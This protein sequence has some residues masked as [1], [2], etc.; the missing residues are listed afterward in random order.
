MQ[1]HKLMIRT[2]V[3]VMLVAYALLAFSSCAPASS[4]ASENRQEGQADKISIVCTIFPQYDWTRQIIGESNMDRFELTLLIDGRVD[5]H[6]YNPSVHDMATIRNSD[7]LI[8]VGGDSDG[9]LNNVLRDANSDMVTINLL[10]ILGDNVIRD[11]HDHDDDH[12]DHNDDDHDDQGDDHDD[13]DDHEDDDDHD[14][15]HDHEEAYTDEHVW[16]SLRNARLIC[17][18]IAAILSE[19][20]PG[21]AQAYMDNL[22]DFDKKL[23]N[24]DAKY[25]AAADA[26]DVSTLVFA[27]RFPFR[28]LLDDYNLHHYAAFRGCSAETEASFVTI[29]SLADRLNQ[30]DL[31]VV[32]VTECADQSIA[33]TVIDSSANKNQ[34]ILVLDSMQSVTSS[35]IANGA[36]YLSIMESNLTVLKDALS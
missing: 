8:Y 2:V 12:D 33:R 16:L 18:A 5:L 6:S 1:K 28:Y 10:E 11:E 17:D 22:R 20:D 14:D 7:V 36:T 27:A 35:D 31:G 29:I 24:L 26:S 13:D 32:M 4:S 23:S 3:C 15:D 34:R 25:R 21:N 19:I 30:F 9:W